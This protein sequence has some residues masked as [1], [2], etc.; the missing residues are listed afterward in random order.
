MTLWDVSR[1]MMHTEKPRSTRIAAL[2]SV[3]VVFDVPPLWLIIAQISAIAPPI[4]VLISPEGCFESI[5]FQSTKKP[6]IGDGSSVF[7]PAGSFV[8]SNISA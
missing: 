2:C 7:V 8:Q 6:A 4:H 3:A 5:I 1:S